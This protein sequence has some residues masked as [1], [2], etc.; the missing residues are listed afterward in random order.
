M[1]EIYRYEKDADNIVTITIDMPGR[2]VNTMNDA[3][4]DGLLAVIDRVEQEQALTGVILTS[5]KDS[6]VAGGDLK[7]L[8]R[9]TEDNKQEFFHRLE[10]A[11]QALRRLELL[12]RPVVAALT[13]TALGGGLELALACHH[14][15]AID[16]PKAEF[17]LPEVTLGLLPGAGG[18]TRLV[19][20]MGIERAFPY[21]VEGKRI[22]VARTI[23]E[24]WIDQ[25]ASDLAE[26]MRLAR[27][28]IAQNPAPVQPW[29]EKG[30]KIPGGAA[31]HPKMSRMLLAAPAMTDKKTRGLLPAPEAVIATIAEGSLVDFDTA[32]RIESR[33]FVRLVASPEAKN[34]IST[35]FFGMNSVTSGERRPAGYDKRRFRKVGVLGAGMMGAGIAYACARAGLSVVL[36]DVALDSA[37]K[38][39]AYSAG[40]LDKAIKRGR[41]TEDRKQA[42]LEL[43]QPTGDVQD[44][45][46]CDLIIEAVFEDEKLKDRVIRETEA[47]LKPG[48]IFASN[49]STLPISMLAE[50][51]RDTAKF[52][53]LHFFSPVDKM[54]L[55]EIIRGRDSSDETLAAVFDFVRQIRKL[56][57][58]VN[59]SLG[60]FTSR[61]FATYTDEGLQLLQ[62]GVA[63]VRI[64]SLAKRA[65]MPVGPLAVTDEVSLTLGQKVVATNDRLI[66]E[67]KVKGDHIDRKATE[68][69]IDAMMEQGRGGRAYGGGFYDYHEDGTKS[70]W[71]GL[72]EMWP[73]KEHGFSDRDISDRMIFR[74]VVESLKCLQEGV[75][76][77]VVDGNI[78]SIFG[79]G[80]PYHTGGVF[81]YINTYG[82]D[83]FIA[84]CRELAERHGPRFNPPEILLAQAEEGELFT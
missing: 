45:A 52:I 56:P 64:D 30:Y 83:R 48:V 46:D 53:G 34:L 19:R 57:I 74:Q 76:D 73:E 70:I 17:G 13:G 61:V 43:I 59:D 25:L 12:G 54:K 42:L 6:F 29:D 8:L 65:G 4:Q 80:F 66:R 23:K 11:K 40:I 60:F 49:T 9:V 47:V 2:P 71:P 31:N 20:M 41:A 7:S 14:R 22:K 44:L 79:I 77:S 62:E 36:K 1:Q 21:L 81:Q 82:M 37:E 15:I 26:M 67:G 16:N 72:R 24:G 50:S 5:G 35:F 33:A 32:L 3:F 10:T 18:L 28:Y 75:L 84:R 63:P 68:E 51:A 39:K 78:G 55:V 38:G 58:V 27:D 69:V